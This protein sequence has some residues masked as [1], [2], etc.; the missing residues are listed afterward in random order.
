M[1]SS[2]PVILNKMVAHVLEVDRQLGHYGLRGLPGWITQEQGVDRLLDHGIDSLPI[3]I[4]PTGFMW[5]ADKAFPWS[6][7][8]CKAAVIGYAVK[9]HGDFDDYWNHLRGK[10]EMSNGYAF[11]H[12]R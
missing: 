10:W 9:W 6:A 4:R 8:E 7:E 2:P 5:P 3:D 12:Q 11:L 1:G